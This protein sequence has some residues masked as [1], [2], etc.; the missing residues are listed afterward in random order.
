MEETELFE[1]L[2]AHRTV[3]RFAG[4]EVDEGLVE[5]CVAAAQCAAT[6]S[7]VQAYSVIRVRDSAERE[8]LAELC[9]GQR[10]VSEAGAFFVLC[11]DQ[12][13]HRLVVERAG[14]VFRPDFDAFLV[15][16]IDV[17]LFA[18]NLALGFEAAGLGVCFIGGL[19]NRLE[20]VDRLL[21]LP[22][23]LFALFGLCVGE[24]AEEPPRR[25]RLPLGSVLSE[26][27]YPTDEH[28]LAGVAAHDRAMARAYAA[29]GKPGR[30]WSGGIARLFAAARRADVGAFYRAKGAGLD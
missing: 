2:G 11:A 3:R 8:R 28:V 25:P 4:G 22:S 29:A 21:E 24:A 20:E 12:R 14:S 6:S 9:G 5:R 10:Q 26:G 13:R 15:A 30:T 16:V 7:H 19:R 27:R 17:A 18:Q 1:L 23:D